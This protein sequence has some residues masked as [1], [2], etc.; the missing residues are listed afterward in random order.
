MAA[1]ILKKQLGT[2]EHVTVYHLPAEDNYRKYVKVENEAEFGHFFSDEVYVIDIQ[3]SDHRYMVNWQGT[4]IDGG[5]QA[6][7]NETMNDMCG[8]IISSDM[9]RNYIRQCQEPE[10][11]LQFFPKGFVVLQGKRCDMK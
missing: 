10:D 1:S 5:M 6:K 2:L 3:G 4:K 9:S 11:L 7:C 8:G